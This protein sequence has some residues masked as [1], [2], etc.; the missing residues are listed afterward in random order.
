LNRRSL[1]F[2]QSH[3]EFPEPD[4]HMN[5]RLNMAINLVALDRPDEAEEQFRIVQQVA[6]GPLPDSFAFWRYSQ[7]L[8]HS[9]GELW[10]SRGDLGRA[11]GY[12]EQCL[13]L[14]EGNISRKY[15]VQGRRLQAQVRMAEGGLD[16]AEQD[17]AVAL[18]LA[19]DVGNPPQLWK[20][21]AALG[22]LRLAQGRAKEARQPYREALS[23]IDTVAA[24]LTDEELRD[25]FLASNDVEQIRRAASAG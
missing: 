12:A 22:D 21:Y 2:V 16:E 11:A 18:E 1:E 14:A 19:H 25:T 3:P 4:I 17:L 7:R 24:S 6:E 5:A 10:L 23:V 15:I 20:T 9:Y 13:D 8:Y